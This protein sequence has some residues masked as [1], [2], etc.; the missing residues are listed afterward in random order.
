VKDGV[1]NADLREQFEHN[2]RVRELVSM[3]N[4]TAE[5]IRELQAKLKESG[6]QGK[7][8]QINEL[9]SEFITSRIRYSKPELLT[10][11]TYL[12]TVTN[13]SDQK[14]GRDVVERY[15]YLRKQMGQFTAKLN[16]LLGTA[17]Q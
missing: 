5:Q 15:A 17:T 6:D 3:A 2:M 11:I 14:I 12:Y 10:Q 1:T 9:S 4:Q 8:A 7:L 16:A 13:S